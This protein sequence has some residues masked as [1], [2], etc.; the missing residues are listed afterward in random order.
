MKRAGV[1]L[2]PQALQEIEEAEAWYLER[3]ARAAEAFLRELEYG[4]VL[5]REAPDSWPR[6]EAGT[7]RYPL[8]SYPYSIVYRQT[9][10][11]IQVVAVA[12]HRRK[13]MYWRAR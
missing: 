13:P 5:V 6:Y 8:R 9:R 11:G 2:L 12:H 1:E 3:S 7:R 10:Q 4:F